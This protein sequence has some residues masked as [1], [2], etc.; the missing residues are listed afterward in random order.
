M[1]DDWVTTRGLRH[2]V[3]EQPATEAHGQKREDLLNIK[4]IILPKHKLY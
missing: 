2:V 4:S 3:E 1:Q